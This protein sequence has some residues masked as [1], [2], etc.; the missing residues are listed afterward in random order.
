MKEQGEDWKSTWNADVNSLRNFIFIF[1]RK[2]AMQF[3]YGC[4]RL[5]G[6]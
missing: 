1:F 6:C 4:A 3:R 5:A 2:F